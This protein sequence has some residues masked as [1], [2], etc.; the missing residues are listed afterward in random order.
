MEDIGVASG[1]PPTV[2]LSPGSSTLFLTFEGTREAKVRD[3][4]TRLRIALAGIQAPRLWRL[5]GEAK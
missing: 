4:E 2:D 5:L 1:R 3:T